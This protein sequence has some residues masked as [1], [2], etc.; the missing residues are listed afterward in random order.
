MSSVAST[1]PCGSAGLPASTPP[2]QAL[3][4]RLFWRLL[5]SQLEEWF[6]SE[7]SHGAVRKA[8]NNHDAAIWSSVAKN[9]CTKKLLCSW[10]SFKSLLREKLP[11]SFR[12]N[13]TQKFKPHSLPKHKPK[14]IFKILLTQQ[15]LS[16]GLCLSKLVLFLFFTHQIDMQQPSVS[17]YWSHSLKSYAWLC[18]RGIV[19]LILSQLSC[20]SLDKLIFSSLLLQ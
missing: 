5:W 16:F 13:A 9:F 6:S 11:Q 15:R 19:F 10:L 3:R 1:S 4:K 7:I 17:Y 14:L 20:Y 12:L 18:N 8:S 2:F